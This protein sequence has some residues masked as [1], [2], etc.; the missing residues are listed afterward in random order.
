MEFA[1]YVQQMALRKDLMQQRILSLE[2]LLTPTKKP[3]YDTESNADRFEDLDIYKESYKTI[4][5]DKHKI[6]V[7]L[8]VP[9]RLNNGEAHLCPVILSFHGGALVSTDESF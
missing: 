6:S 3:G 7:Y 1:A 5:H 2:K 9:K 8:L 4:G